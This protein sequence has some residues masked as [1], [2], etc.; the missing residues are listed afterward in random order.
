[1]RNEYKIFVGKPAGETSQSWVHGRQQDFF[2][3]P[4]GITT[5]FV[6]VVTFKLFKATF[7]DQN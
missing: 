7:P 3:G 1:M 5:K 6:Y 2:Q 4:G